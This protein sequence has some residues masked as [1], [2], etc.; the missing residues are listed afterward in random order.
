[1]TAPSLHDYDDIHTHRPP[2]ANGSEDGLRRIL[3]IDPSETVTLPDCPV[4]VGIH[5]WSPQPDAATLER[6]DTMARSANVV[7]IGEAGLDR[8]RGAPM[9][10]QEALFVHHARLAQE[11]G[12]PLIIHC[13]RAYDVLLRLH[14]RLRP[15]IPWVVHG[16]RG[17][18]ALARQLTDA[19]IG[20]S[21]GPRFNPQVPGAVPR[22]MLYT[23]TDT[24]PLPPPHIP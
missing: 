11:L 18:V 22:Q 21:L 19:G 3:N 4:S 23:E 15:S 13:V 20:L 8:L 7:A 10:I 2:L 5:P 12:K 1:M 9:D 17:G 16:F 14:K 6:L 24:S